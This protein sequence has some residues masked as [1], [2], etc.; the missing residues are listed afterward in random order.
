MLLQI[1]HA[2]DTVNV[3]TETDAVQMALERQLAEKNRLEKEVERWKA[4]DG[5]ELER[6]RNEMA[7]LE[8]VKEEA[9]LDLRRLERQYDIPVLLP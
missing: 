1:F 9:V 7:S 6:L 3:L 5:K 8:K 4:S 2:I